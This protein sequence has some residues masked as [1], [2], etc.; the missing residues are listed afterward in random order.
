M[1]LKRDKYDTLFSNMVRER[2]NW[3]CQ[4][5]GK[6]YPEGERQGLHCS[7]IFSR[8]H[9]ATRWEPY[10]AVAHCYSCHQYLGG[11]PVIFEAW[12]RTYLGDYVLNL[13]EEKHRL[14]IKVTKKDK[15]EMYK[16]MKSEHA[17]MLKLRAG[18]DTGLLSFTGYL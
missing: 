3:T 10:N 7:H 6:Y 2:D 14:I 4:K 13:L 8:R 17:R 16:H 15:I 18:G 11:N 12:A 5:C 1:G 9:R